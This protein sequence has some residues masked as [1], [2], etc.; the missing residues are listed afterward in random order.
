MTDFNELLA[1]AFEDRSVW[2]YEGFDT[3][4]SI[5]QRLKVPKTAPVDTADDEK[6]LWAFVRARDLPHAW[7]RLVLSLLH[8]TVLNLDDVKSAIG[9]YESAKLTGGFNDLRTLLKLRRVEAEVEEIAARCIEED[10]EWEGLDVDVYAA[11]ATIPNYRE[12][13]CVARR[14]KK[15]EEAAEKMAEKYREVEEAAKDAAERAKA[16]YQEFEKAAERAADEN[17]DLEESN[18]FLRA[19]NAK[20]EEQLR[21]M[22][23]VQMTYEFERAELRKDIAQL[24]EELADAQ[25]RSTAEERVLL[26]QVE[27]T[28]GGQRGEQSDELGWET[29]SD[30]DG[31]SIAELPIGDGEPQ[32]ASKCEGTV[33]VTGDKRKRRHSNAEYQEA[34]EAGFGQNEGNEVIVIE[35][36]DDDNAQDAEGGVAAGGDLLS[37]KSMSPAV[38]EAIVR[39]HEGSTRYMRNIRSLFEM[40]PTGPSLLNVRE[41]LQ[42]ALETPRGKHGV[43]LESNKDYVHAYGILL[44][45][46]KEDEIVEYVGTPE[47]FEDVVATQKEFDYILKER[48]NEQVREQKLSD[49]EITMLRGLKWPDV[50]TKSREYIQK[51]NE[52]R[53]SKSHVDTVKEL[54]MLA[55]AMLYGSGEHPPRRL[56]VLRI[57][58]GTYTD[59]GNYYEGQEIVLNDY[60]TSDVYGQ[61]RMPISNEIR[62]VLDLLA[63]SSGESGEQFIF[64]KAEQVDKEE[65]E[66]EKENG[67]CSKLVTTTF[68]EICGRPL[69]VGVLRKLYITHKGDIG[70]LRYAKERIRLAKMMGHSVTLQQTVYTI[71]WPEAGLT[72]IGDHTDT[73]PSKRRKRVRERATKKLATPD[74]DAALLRA[75]QEYVDKSPE[76]KAQRKEGRTISF[77]WAHLKAKCPELA[78][79]P[80]DT[81]AQWG[82]R[83]K[84][85][86]SEG[87]T[88]DEGSCSC[89]GESG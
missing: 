45:N 68:S 62:G 79:V 27:A 21:E 53:L 70:E 80:R 44:R 72:E 25:D 66:K 63:D 88:D 35:D 74:E 60:K 22:K 46:M 41:T 15:L 3:V 33:K 82:K 57:R 76:Y 54:R 86:L 85:K 52:K 43:R 83:L 59:T 23:E 9:I 28:L 30:T 31:K 11:I 81:I 55:I 65:N 89:F 29:S 47:K 20:L 12:Q 71:R 13:I 67:H 18:E 24:T 77:P 5:V 87:V 36:D 42:W 32:L 75:M 7:V 37:A 8:Y 64:G 17:E 16:E 14:F 49:R 50:E 34:N 56:E 38:A 2:I 58:R 1:D 26:R 84:A 6:A 69:T 51:Q 48:R 40:C 19:R 10:I 73:P 61:Y 39:R 4:L 78:D